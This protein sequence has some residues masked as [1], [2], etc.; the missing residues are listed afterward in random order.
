MVPVA[1]TEISSTS[2]AAS[3]PLMHSIPA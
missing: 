3:S 2:T 1:P